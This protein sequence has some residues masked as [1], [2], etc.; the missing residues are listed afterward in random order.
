[1]GC[2]YCHFR[3]HTVFGDP[4]IETII[5]LIHENMEDGDH[6]RVEINTNFANQGKCKHLYP[7]S[8]VIQYCEFNIHITHNISGNC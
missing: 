4:I 3:H 8:N 7:I 6:E 5:E 1:M 2:K